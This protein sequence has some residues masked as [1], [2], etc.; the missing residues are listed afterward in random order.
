MNPTPWTIAGISLLLWASTAAASSE[1]ALHTGPDG[2]KNVVVKEGDRWVAL[3]DFARPQHIYDF[4]ASPDGKRAFVWHMDVPPRTVSVYDLKSRRRTASFRPGYG[5]TL[6]WTPANTLLHIW[7]A[8]TA[9]RLFKV[10]DRRAKV[11]CGTMTESLVASPGLRFLAAHPVIAGRERLRVWDLTMNRLVIDRETEGEP[12]FYLSVRWE[13]DHTLHLLYA[14]EDGK[15]TKDVSVAV[16]PWR[17]TSLELS[18]LGQSLFLRDGAEERLLFRAV[19]PARG[20]SSA[21]VRRVHSVVTAP[22]ARAAA[23]LVTRNRQTVLLPIRIDGEGRLAFGTAVPVPGACDASFS[24]R[25][26]ALLLVSTRDAYLPCE[27]PFAPN[28]G[29]ML[30]K[31]DG[32]EWQSTIEAALDA[33]GKGPWYARPGDRFVAVGDFEVLAV[34]WRDGACILSTKAAGAAKRTVTLL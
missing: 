15:K 1:L 22:G 28:R 2:R 8:G 20:R 30:L 24:P 4:A 7:G 9:V 29:A 33:K 31:L 19:L 11:L 34:R 3:T 21:D 25:S 12:W 23:V 13:G 32:I 18:V 17:R 10:Y 27:A 26:D 6:R 14:E 16:R 5:G